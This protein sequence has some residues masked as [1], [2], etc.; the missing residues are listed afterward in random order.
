MEFKG[1]QGEWRTVEKNRVVYV[2]N[3][4]HTLIAEIDRDITLG[5][6]QATPEATYFNIKIIKAAPDLLCVAEMTYGLLDKIHHPQIDYIRGS[7]RTAIEK[8]LK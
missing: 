4:D 3:E 5:F 7:L 6:N 1:S 8:A 2:I